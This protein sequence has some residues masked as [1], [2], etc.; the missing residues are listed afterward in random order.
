MLQAPP[1]DNGGRVRLLN[2]ADKSGQTPWI[3]RCTASYTTATEAESVKGSLCTY[4]TIFSQLCWWLL[5]SSPYI[6]LPKNGELSTSEKP[7]SRVKKR[8]SAISIDGKEL[9]RRSSSDTWGHGPRRSMGRLDAIWR[10]L[11]RSQILPIVPLQ[12]GED[13]VLSCL[14]LIHI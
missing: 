13:L 7:R 9:G 11:G 5:G 6:F 14:S 10:I 4:G 3:K 8:D 2:G 12:D 1:A